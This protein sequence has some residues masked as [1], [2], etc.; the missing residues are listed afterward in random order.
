MFVWRSIKKNQRL[1]LRFSPFIPRLLLIGACTLSFSACLLVGVNQT[2][3]LAS[4]HVTPS[5]L[6]SPSPSTP[7][8]SP[9]R[10]GW[11]L[12]SLEKKIREWL[13]VFIVPLVLGGVGYWLNR[14]ADERRKEEESDAEKIRKDEAKERRI[15][16][17]LK[18]KE[19]RYQE[20]LKSYLDRM[21]ELLVDKELGGAE[22]NSYIASVGQALTVTILR[23][24]DEDIERR[25]QVADF[26]YDAGLIQTRNLSKEEIEKKAYELWKEAGQT[27]NLDD[28]FWDRAKEELERQIGAPVLEFEGPVL[29]KESRLNKAKLDNIV[30]TKVN[31][32]FSNLVE[33]NLEGANLEGAHMGRANLRAADLGRANLY[34][35]NLREAILE[36]ADLRDASLIGANLEGANLYRADLK[37]AN[38]AE[39]DLEGATL[40][41]ANLAEADLEGADLKEATLERADLEGANLEGADLEGATLYEANLR[42]ADLEG[43]NLEGATLRGANLQDAVIAEITYNDKTTWP[44]DFTPPSSAVNTDSI[45]DEA[46]SNTP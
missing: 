20:S 9:P 34:K 31:L 33:A 41:R 7:S 14:R 32:Q 28:D 11:E 30:L 5:A 44:T 2:S 43:A 18:S 35:A 46:P 27:K 29:L 13:D 15:E 39:A 26:L 22:H 6:P 16:E 40:Y 23:E 4:S 37:G 38:L 17:S 8:Q 45:Q 1:Q 10:D 25:S 24:L 19:R 21:T 3:S 42:R 36:R 12:E